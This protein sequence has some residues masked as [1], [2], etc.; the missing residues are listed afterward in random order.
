M[1]CAPA[2]AVPVIWSE[3]MIGAI[4]STVAKLKEK[5]PASGLPP[6]S[7]TLVSVAV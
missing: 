5:V 1:I 7:V 6:V 4:V 3:V 2:R